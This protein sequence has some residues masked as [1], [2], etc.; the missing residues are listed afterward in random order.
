MGHVHQPANDCATS[1]VRAQL[2][3]N[4]LEIGAQISRALRPLSVTLVLI[5]PTRITGKR[6]G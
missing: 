1:T 4:D 5:G 2:I 6:E 3:L